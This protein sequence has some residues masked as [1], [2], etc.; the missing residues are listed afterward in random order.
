MSRQ[1]KAAR[2]DAKRFGPWAV[3]TGASSG[4][5]REAARQLAAN[6]I[7]LVLVA[8]Q[9]TA[10]E[11]LGQELQ[12]RHGISYQVVVADLSS[13]EGTQKVIEE[14]R[15][16]DVGLLVSNAGTGQ[17]GDF[18]AFEE[19]DLREIVE[20]NGVSHMILAHEFGRRMVQRRRNGGV[21]LVSALGVDTGIPFHTHAVAAKGVV[22]ALG[23]SLHY[24]FTKLGLNLSVLAVP[25]TD[26]AAIGKLGLQGSDISFGLMPIQQVVYEGL[27][28][29]RSNK[30]II[31]PG[32]LFRFVN[33]LVPG[34]ALRKM[35]GEVMRKSR[36]FVS[37]TPTTP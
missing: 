7:D 20:L 29:L 21:L 16:R 15:H 28:G 23:R 34:N 31:L 8:R 5:G 22:N 30:M 24:E 17:P 25:L 14:T 27:M 1:A 19:N 37:W 10:L 18:L 13:E 6:R 4:I 12:A 33:V 36:T 26:T 32:R 2:I 9:S 3:V 35:F 11:Q